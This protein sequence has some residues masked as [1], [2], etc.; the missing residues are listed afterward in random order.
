[1]RLL[2][3]DNYDS[4]THNLVQLFYHF[5]IEVLVY[6]HDAVTVPEIEAMAPHWICLSPGPKDPSH[7]GIC[8]EVVVRLGRRI[9]ILGVCLGMQVI[10]EVFG[11]RT[12]RAPIPVHGKRS[13]VHHQGLGVFRNLPS[14]FWAARYHSLQVIPGSD[15]LEVV[16]FA[17]DGVAMG[18]RH[19]SRPIHGVQFHPESF[20]SEF[21][22][23]LAANFLE[24]C[25]AWAK[26]SDS[27]PKPA[28]TPWKPDLSFLPV[29]GAS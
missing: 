27:L 9:P 6:R 8:K 7:T 10:N 1:M 13:R 12:C 26:I 3:I 19:R 23:E 24:T 17:S 29:P 2:M 28:S 21:G 25:P 11:G 5:H 16:A 15:E 14:P 4:F 22:W 20:L 18:I